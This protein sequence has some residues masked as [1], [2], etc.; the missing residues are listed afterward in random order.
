LAA[1][2]VTKE[3]KGKGGKKKKLE[4]Q[5]PQEKKE[6]GETE[7]GDDR[8]GVHAVEM[9][10]TFF[11]GWDSGTEVTRAGIWEEQVWSYLTKRRK[12]ET[13]LCVGGT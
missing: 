7:K 6:Q 10:R 13:Y 9:I 4:A 8:F 2:K 12:R 5:R 11:L 3:G 1:G